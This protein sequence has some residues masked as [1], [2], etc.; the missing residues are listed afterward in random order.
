MLMVVL[1]WHLNIPVTVYLRLWGPHHLTCRLRY[2]LAESGWP[3]LVQD[4]VPKSMMWATMKRLAHHWKS[5]MVNGALGYI[6]TS[7]CKLTFPPHIQSSEGRYHMSPAAAK[8]FRW[9]NPTVK[10]I[11]QSLLCQFF[12]MSWYQYQHRYKVLNTLIYLPWN[13]SPEQT[14]L[15]NASK[16]HNT[17]YQILWEFYFHKKLNL[18]LTIKCIR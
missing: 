18:I 2:S 7:H 11:I 6:G 12:K 9:F 16:N 15:L 10:L 17:I 13:L 1:Q 3:G 8:S 4:M 14:K 5:S